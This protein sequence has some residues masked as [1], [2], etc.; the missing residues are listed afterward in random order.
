[1]KEY[2]SHFSAAEMWDIQYI[3]AILDKIRE[4]KQEIA[5]KKYINMVLFIYNRHKRV[6]QS[7]NL[8]FLSEGLCLSSIT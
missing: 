8:I 4:Q 1:M 3:E 7:H 5:C 6:L 2:L